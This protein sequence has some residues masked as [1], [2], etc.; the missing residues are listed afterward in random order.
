MCQN[1]PINFSELR[2]ENTHID[3][4]AAFMSIK[5]LAFYSV[6]WGVP[7]VVQQK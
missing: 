3:L 5:V 7:T 2:R 1:M 4:W 6:V